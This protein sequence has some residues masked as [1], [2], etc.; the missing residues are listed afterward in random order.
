MTDQNL[1][2]YVSSRSHAWCGAT[3]YK[4]GQGIKADYIHDALYQVILPVLFSCGQ[5]PPSIVETQGFGFVLCVI[6]APQGGEMKYVK[7]MRHDTHQMYFIGFR[8]WIAMLTA[9]L[10][11]IP[12]Q[13]HDV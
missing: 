10:E 2:K 6:Q 12:V 9:F 5:M 3:F 8:T 13:P 1:R 7:W 4:V 11:A